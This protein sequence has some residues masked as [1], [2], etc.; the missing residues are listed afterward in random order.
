MKFDTVKSIIAEWLEERTLPDLIERDVVPIDFSKLTDIIA[1][2]GPRRAGKTYYMYQLIQHLLNSGAVKEEILF[3]DFEDY[4]LINTSASDIDQLFTAFRQ[5]TGRQPTYLFFDEIQ[6]FPQWNRVLRTLHNQ[7]RYK[8]IISGSNSKLLSREIATEL[9]GRYRD[10]IML[11]LSFSEFLRFKSF[12]YNE[13]MIFTS[14]RGEFL[15]L[16]DGYL[17]GGGFPEVIQRDTNREKRELLQS[18][19]RTLFYHDIIERYNIKSRSILE[20]LMSYCIEAYAELFS[21]SGFAKY[22]H[23]YDLAVSKKTI[24]NYL[25]YLRDAFFI[26]LNDKFS[27]S[28]RKR[29]MNPKKVYLFDNG[30]AFLGTAFSENRGKLLENSVAIEL[31]RRQQ[32]IFYFKDHNECDFIVKQGLK[33]TEAIQVTW[34]LTATSRHRELKG[35]IEAMRSLNLTQGKILTYSQEEQIAL[36]GHS[37]QVVPVWKWLLGAQLD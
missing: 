2:V 12:E 5:L 30:F 27:F 37:I 31:L 15:E 34:E 20:I 7:G 14:A 24:S 4:R 8:I 13:R 19:Y 1:I 22:L 26:I 21:I 6:Q 11:P 28:P 3:I 36:E 25:N 16:F 33:P 18:Y 10:R 29:L 35:L 17:R 9:R 23:D 32:E